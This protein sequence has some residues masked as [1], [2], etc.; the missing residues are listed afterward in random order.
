MTACID[1][2]VS[3]LKLELFALDARDAEVA[4]HVAACPVCARCLH[5]IRAD[6]VALPPL[7]QPGL[8]QVARRRTWWIAP[9]MAF[10]AAAVV[11]LVLV[12]RGDEAPQREDVTRVKGIGDVT[13]S[14]VRD[15]AGTIRM[16]VRTF[17]AGDRWKLVVTCSP[18]PTAAVW[19]DAAVVDAGA[20]DYPLAPARV[21]C[22]NGIVVPGAFTI[23]GSRSNLVCARVDATTTPLRAPPR[24][25][26]P[27]VACVTLRPE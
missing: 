26:E 10:A 25:G 21:T 12:R 8:P 1:Q 13:L 7:A 11:V 6:V 9:A 14:V 22:G 27:N 2:P 3:W 15:R 18:G 23:T 20:V 24:P 5:E 19:I 4:S 16:D 17:A